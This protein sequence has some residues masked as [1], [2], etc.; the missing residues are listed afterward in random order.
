[1]PDRTRLILHQPTGGLCNRIHALDG[2]IVLAQ[3]TGRQLIVVWHRRRDFNC[4]FDELFEFP[5]GVDRM[6]SSPLFYGLVWRLQKIMPESVPGVFHRYHDL[7]VR[8]ISRQLADPQAAADLRRY[9]LL[10]FVTCSRPIAG[11]PGYPWLKPVAAIREQVARDTQR[12]A[13]RPTFGVHI[14]RTDH[15]RSILHSPTEVF[16]EHMQ[17]TIDEQRAQGRDAQFFLATDSPAEEA[18][19]RAQFGDR[20]LTRHRQS[21]DRNDPAGIRDA[22]VDLLCLSSTRG[23]IGSYN[24]SFSHVAASIGGIRLT[25]ASRD[26][27]VT[28][29][30]PA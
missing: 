7:N 28:P 6:I 5:A 13:D 29:R 21:L 20:I 15:Q 23:I 19:M 10:L 9:P 18:A 30:D 27:R 16:V 12:F 11:T 1:M 4:A 26:L 17:A 24:S 25:V 22:L 8:N 14:R 3:R 2:A